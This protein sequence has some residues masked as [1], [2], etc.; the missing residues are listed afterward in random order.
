MTGLLLFLKELLLCYFSYIELYTRNIWIFQV[1][2]IQLSWR[3]YSLL[4]FDWTEYIYIYMCVCVCVCVCIYIE[5]NKYPL[6]ELKK[7]FFYIIG[8]LSEEIIL[9]HEEDSR[10]K[11]IIAKWRFAEFFKSFTHTHT[12]VRAHAHAHTQTH[13]HI[14]IYIGNSQF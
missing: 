1:W 7:N 11:F 2:I 14:Y 4:R 12:H 9:S 13:R 8:W 5:M 3:N 6:K 10:N